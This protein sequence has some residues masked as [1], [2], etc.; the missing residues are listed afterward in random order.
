[1]AR[2]N[3]GTL[4]KSKEGPP[5]NDVIE[6]WPKEGDAPLSRSRRMQRRSSLGCYFKSGMFERNVIW[7]RWV[8][9]PARNRFQRRFLGKF[10]HGKAIDIGPCNQIYVMISYQTLWRVAMGL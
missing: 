7:T 10:S 2:R 6:L 1:M 4:S 8:A 9:V 3:T 5:A